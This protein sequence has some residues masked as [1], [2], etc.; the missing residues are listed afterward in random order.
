MSEVLRRDAVYQDQNF[1]DDLSYYLQKTVRATSYREDVYFV[2][3]L[4]YN[5]PTSALR[6]NRSIEDSLSVLLT[7]QP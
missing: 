3:G 5:P 2:H 7:V 6:G 4:K 1:Q